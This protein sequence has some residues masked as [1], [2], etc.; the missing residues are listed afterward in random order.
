MKKYVGWAVAGGLWLA[1]DLFSRI[2]LYAPYNWC[3]LHSADVNDWA[4]ID[5]WTKVE[6]EKEK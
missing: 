6:K 4:G 3:M 1:G 5:L 2:G